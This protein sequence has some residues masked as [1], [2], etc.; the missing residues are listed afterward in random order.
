M[1]VRKKSSK[2]SAQVHFPVR[3][4]WKIKR[5]LENLEIWK[6]IKSLYVCPCK[7]HDSITAEKVIFQKLKNEGDSYYDFV[8][9]SDCKLSWKWRLVNN[10][11]HFWP[12]WYMV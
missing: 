8:F 2:Y 3:W 5:E 9:D 4:V 7:F 1:K 11:E 6:T 12:H 10:G